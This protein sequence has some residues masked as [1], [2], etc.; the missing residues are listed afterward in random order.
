MF[1][2]DVF[3]DNSAYAADRSRGYTG[4]ALTVNI[5]MHSH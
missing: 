4:E 2:S 3:A 5:R 1:V